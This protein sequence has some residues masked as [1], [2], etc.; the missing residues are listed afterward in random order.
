MDT[1]SESSER[2]TRP[3]LAEIRERLLCK[4]TAERFTGYEGLMVDPNLTTKGNITRLQRAINYMTRRKIRFASFQSCFDQ[5]KKDYDETLEDV[6][7]KKR[8]AL[9]SRKLH[10][11]VL[12]YN[13]LAY[14][15]VSLRFIRYNIKAIEEICKSEPDNWK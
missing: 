7:I 1:D 6:K 13:Q 11:L 15:T 2:K 4:R 9:F 10:K 14:C 8:W 5:S 12:E 3:N